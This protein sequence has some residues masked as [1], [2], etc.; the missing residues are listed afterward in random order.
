MEFP[1]INLRTQE[2]IRIKVKLAT[3]I[4]KKAITDYIRDHINE[5]KMDW[6]FFKDVKTSYHKTLKQH[7][8]SDSVPGS[9]WLSPDV[10][11]YKGECNKVDPII[12]LLPENNSIIIQ[13][14]V[15]IKIS[16]KQDSDIIIATERLNDSVEHY[17]FTIN[18]TDITNSKLYII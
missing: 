18:A 10:P 4:D 17:R 13:C 11:V 3:T 6:I 14:P 16:K 1:A 7:L 5:T 8:N 12:C 15:E 9:D 2:V